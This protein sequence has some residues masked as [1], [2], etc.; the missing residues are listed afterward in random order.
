MKMN[1]KKKIYKKLLH[2]CDER[3]KKTATMMIFR[4][5][6]ILGIEWHSKHILS[7]LNMEV[8]NVCTL[9]NETERSLFAIF[10]VFFSFV[11]SFAFAIITFVYFAGKVH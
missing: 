10:T 2:S 11:F 5:M 1:R 7:G 3:E 4:L 9:E 6:L 8:W